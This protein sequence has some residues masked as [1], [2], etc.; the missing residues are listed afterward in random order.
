MMEVNF[1]TKEEFERVTKVLEVMVDRLNG[2]Q[3]EFKSSQL[4]TNNQM[5]EKLSVSKKTLSHWRNEGKLQFF[6]IGRKIFYSE[7]HLVNFLSRNKR[8][9]FNH[10]KI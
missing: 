1:I 10:L 8:E 9:L 2:L 6:Q 7:D 4:Y 3:R 5:A